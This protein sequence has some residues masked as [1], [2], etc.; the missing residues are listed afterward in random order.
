VLEYFNSTHG[1]RKGL[2]D[3]ALKTANSGYLTRRLV[4]VA[5]DVHH[6]DGRLR[7]RERR[8]HAPI[9]EGGE[10]VEPLASAC[11]AARRGRGRLRPGDR[12]PIVTRDTLL[13]EAL[14]EKLDKAGV[15]IVKIRS[16]LTCAAARCLQ[17]RRLRR[18]RCYG[19]CAIGGAASLQ[20]RWTTRH[21]S[22]STC[23]EACRRHRRATV[24]RRAGHAA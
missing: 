6:H 17:I 11:W 10:V 21:R 15:Q 2:A 8:H 5:Q 3:T 1:A 24:D 12:Q 18:S 13:D 9:I 7:H 23:G 4:D 20:R 22:W 14:V 16:P 19:P